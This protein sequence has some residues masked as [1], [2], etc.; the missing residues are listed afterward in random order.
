[1]TADVVVGG[2]CVLDVQRSAAGRCRVLVYGWGT[3]GTGGSN[4][5]RFDINTGAY[6]CRLVVGAA[7]VCRWF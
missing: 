6:V 7:V 5:F 3:R 1:M 2:C 4:L